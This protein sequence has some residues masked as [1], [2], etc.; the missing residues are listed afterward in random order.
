MPEVKQQ[1]ADENPEVATTARE[2]ALAK[3]TPEQLLK[4]AGVVDR[5]RVKALFRAIRVID[6]STEQPS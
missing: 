2:K 4:D 6:N 5:K 1:I 3:L